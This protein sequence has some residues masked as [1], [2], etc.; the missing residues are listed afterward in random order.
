MPHPPASSADIKLNSA[1]SPTDYF[2]A[3]VRTARL[4][5]YKL[6]VTAEDSVNNFMTGALRLEHSFTSTVA[7]LAPPPTANEALVPGMI[8]VLVS[9][10]A[11]SI[12]TRN[13]NI[14]LRATVPVIFGVTAGYVAIPVTMRNVGN[15][16]W[17]Y[18]EK[19]PVV[20][21]THLQIKER[22][23]YIWETG[24]AHTGMTVSRTEGLLDEARTK[25][26]DWVKKGK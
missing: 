5:L 19:Y 26:E 4:Q 7:S 17:K 22:A 24:K 25:M 15:L 8:Y 13:R 6:S 10:M 18:E 3:Q 1:T 16:V 9:A 11:G 23:Q 2:T 20:R 12:I 21:D 14:L